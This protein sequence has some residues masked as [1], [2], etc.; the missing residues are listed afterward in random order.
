MSI[1]EFRKRNTRRSQKT[2]T[3]AHIRQMFITPLGAWSGWF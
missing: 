1:V 2:L 3:P